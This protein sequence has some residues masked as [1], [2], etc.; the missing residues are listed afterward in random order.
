MNLKTTFFLIVLLGAGV[1]GW[2]WL[3]TQKV[4]EPIAP[5]LPYFNEGFQAKKIQRV[6]VPAAKTRALVLERNGDDG[7]C[8]AMARTQ[9]S[10]QWID[11][12]AKLRSRCAHSDQG[13]ST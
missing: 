6:E 2:Y 1:G 3:Q 4:A 12:L 13:W 8:P 11:E 7:R 9:E 10:E 5:T